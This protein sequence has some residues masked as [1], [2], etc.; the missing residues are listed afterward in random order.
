MKPIAINDL[1]VGTKIHYT[2]DMANP[3]GNGRVVAVHLNP[4]FGDDVEVAL[5]AQPD[6]NGHADGSVPAR[7]FRISPAN[8]SR[9]LGCRFWLRTEWIAKRRA[10]FADSLKHY[11]GITDEKIAEILAKFDRNHAGVA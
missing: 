9:G 7:T 6:E 3:S 5:D 11:P 1:Q 10:S 2:G 4:R 8:F